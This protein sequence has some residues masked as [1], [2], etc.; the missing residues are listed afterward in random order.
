MGLGRKYRSHVVGETEMFSPLVNND[1]SSGQRQEDEEASFGMDF[2]R[3][4]EFEG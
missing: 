3:N 2:G 1:G 4:R